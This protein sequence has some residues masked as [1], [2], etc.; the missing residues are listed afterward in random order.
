MISYQNGWTDPWVIDDTGD[1]LQQLLEA[2]HDIVLAKK[3]CSKKKR[4]SVGSLSPR[5]IFGLGPGF[6]RK[7]LNQSRRRLVTKLHPDRWHS[8]S[9]SERLAREEVLKR[10]NAA[11][12]EL[13]TQAR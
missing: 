2:S 6:T 4:R 9:P 3:S 7:Q 8:A 11:F 5:E 13:R 12:D 10:V 1:R